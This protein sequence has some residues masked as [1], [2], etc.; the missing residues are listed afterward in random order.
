MLPDL[1]LDIVHADTVED[2]VEIASL[3]PGKSVAERE[4][5]ICR[6][7]VPN[8]VAMTEGRG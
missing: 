7:L 3:Y 1:S 6:H 4:E 8:F 5:M 2:V